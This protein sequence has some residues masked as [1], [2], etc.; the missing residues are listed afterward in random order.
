MPAI[1]TPAL[2][3]FYPLQAWFAD[4][5]GSENETIPCL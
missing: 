4:V 3:V 1:L 5:V 2:S